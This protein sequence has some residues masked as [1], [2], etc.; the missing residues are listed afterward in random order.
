MQFYLT[1]R[2]LWETIKF[3]FSIIYMPSKKCSHSYNTQYPIWKIRQVHTPVKYGIWVYAIII[4]IHHQLG[5]DKPVLA[6]SNSLFKGLPS[7]LH[8]I[9]INYKSD[10]CLT[11]HHWYK[12]YR[13]PNRCNNN[14]LLIIPISST[15]FRR[16]FRPSSGALDCVYRLWYNAPMMLPGSS[17]EVEFLHFQATADNIVGA[18]YHKP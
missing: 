1:V 18:L 5:F 17:L 7:R 8:P 16:W 2:T 9:Y 6:S 15:C 4:I 12:Q 13:Q 11:V 10:I 3:Y 14:G